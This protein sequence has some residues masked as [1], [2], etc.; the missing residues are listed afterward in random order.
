MDVVQITG[1]GDTTTPGAAERLRQAGGLFDPDRFTANTYLVRGERTVL[2]DAG[3]LPGVAAAVEGFTDTLDAV[4][5]THQHGDHVAQL[6][7]V[8]SAF[9]PALYAFGDHPRRTAELVDGETVQLGDEPFEVLHTPGHADDHVVLYSDSTL[10]A[11]DLVAAN[12]QAFDYGSFGG[13]GG[14][15]PARERLIESLERLL[16]A[17]PAGV[18]HLYGGHGDPF[19]GD[20]HDVV[21]TALRRAEERAPKY[22]DR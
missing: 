4:V 14:P 15:G 1:D 9:D 16:D 12:D 8:L 18:E 10:F 20:V 22:P 3:S 2:I 19:H 17:L 5:L 7:A 13:T 11:G 21:A 6:D